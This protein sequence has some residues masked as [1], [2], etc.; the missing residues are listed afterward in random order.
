MSNTN[1]T[2]L[3]AGSRRVREVTK[4]RGFLH[5]DQNVLNAT[6]KQP[7][8]G[9]QSSAGPLRVLGISSGGSSALFAP[10]D[11]V[12]APM[13]VVESKVSWL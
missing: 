3:D 12:L 6:Q 9:T 11:L 7:V 1:E 2:L 5:P 13:F 4:T 8:Q 10:E